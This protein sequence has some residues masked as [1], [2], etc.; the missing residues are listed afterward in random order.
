MIITGVLTQIGSSVIHI[1]WRLCKPADNLLSVKT[2][3]ESGLGIGWRGGLA[4]SAL[5][6]KAVY[7]VVVGR[8]AW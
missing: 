4:G 8:R 2:K 3:Q 6:S 7:E 5:M 1:A